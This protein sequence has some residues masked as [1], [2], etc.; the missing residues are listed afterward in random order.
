MKIGLKT[1]RSQGRSVTRQHKGSNQEDSD[2]DDIDSGYHDSGL[3]PDMNMPSEEYVPGGSS[4][5]SS[6]PHNQR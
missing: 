1:L 5:V 6:Y 3:G 2:D 4:L